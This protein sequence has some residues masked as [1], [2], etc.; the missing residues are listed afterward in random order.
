MCIRDSTSKFMDTLQATLDEEGLPARVQNLG[1]SFY[2]YVG[3]RDPIRN[4]QDFDKLNPELAKTF[5]QKCIEKGV[6]FHT[7]F[8]VSARHDEDTLA[9]AGEI[10]RAAARETKEEM[11]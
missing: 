10:I 2:I 9:K 1:C 7:D 5:F 3:T 4:Y 8:T 11:L 6:Y